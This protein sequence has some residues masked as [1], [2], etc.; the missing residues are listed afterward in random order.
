MSTLIENY[1][2][3]FNAGDYEGMVALLS[4]DVVH[5]PSQGAPR[6]G[7]EQFRSF[8]AHMERC[9]AEKV[10]SP[11]IMSS[12]DGLHAAAE[13]MLTG[14]YLQTDD[15]LPPAHGQSYRLRVGAF[16]EISDGRISRVSNHYN[17][18]DWLRQIGG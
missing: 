4:E 12:G 10:I 15:G 6:V 18:Q 9:Y 2:A 13:F 16:F 5:E 11:V 17:L 14:N 1:Y 7:K 3:C 8:L